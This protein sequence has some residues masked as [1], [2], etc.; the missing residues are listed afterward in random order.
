MN[1]F[2]MIGLAYLAGLAALYRWVGDRTL[3]DLTI[4]L[5]HGVHALGV[6]ATRLR[7]GLRR[8][9]HE[10]GHDEVHVLV[11]TLCLEVV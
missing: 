3:L 8:C 4:G 5:D 11:R 7:A 9:G 10:S 6:D 1:T 2:H